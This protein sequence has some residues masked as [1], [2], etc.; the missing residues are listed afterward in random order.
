[1][2]L[3][4]QKKGLL[5]RKEEALKKSVRGKM[6]C[7]IFD[8][9]GKIHTSIYFRNCQRQRDAINFLVN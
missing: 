1:M 4:F 9:E 8:C 3:R 2:F 7:E 6:R 5:M